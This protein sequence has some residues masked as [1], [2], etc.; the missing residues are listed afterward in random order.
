MPAPQKII[1]IDQTFL[2]LNACGFFSPAFYQTMSQEPVFGRT[3]SAP[4]SLSVTALTFSNLQLPPALQPSSLSPFLRTPRCRC[5]LLPPARDL[6]LSPPP[7]HD[8]SPTYLF[9]TSP[10]STSSTQT[11]STKSARIDAI[12]GYIEL[13][14]IS[15]KILAS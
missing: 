6:N 4:K 2:A 5:S 11:K 8:R 10:Y 3:N 9:L 14:K 12:Y 7:P 15:I 13:K 1:K